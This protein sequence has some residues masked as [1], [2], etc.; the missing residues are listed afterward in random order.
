MPPAAHLMPSPE[1][2]PGQEVQI[3]VYEGAGDASQARVSALH[4]VRAS[5]RSP[6]GSE[7]KEMAWSASG[8]R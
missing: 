3:D 8:G 2:V 1:G 6:H 5:R 4:I 7:R